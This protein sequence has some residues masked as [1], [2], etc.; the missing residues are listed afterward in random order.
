MQALPKKSSTDNCMTPATPP[1]PPTGPVPVPSHAHPTTVTS[2]HPA[3]PAEPALHPKQQP[4]FLEMM[5]SMRTTLDTLQK[6]VEAQAAFLSKPNVAPA[7]HHPTTS[8][9]TTTNNVMD[10]ASSHVCQLN[11]QG[12]YPNSNHFK[13][14]HLEAMITETQTIICLTETHLTP[15]VMDAD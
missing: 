2:I 15:A 11:T 6:A 13:I 1:L 10:K 12:L 5:D 7:S 4:H 3:T 14:P 8:T 9:N